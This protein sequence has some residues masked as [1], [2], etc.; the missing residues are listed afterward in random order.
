[1]KVGTRAAAPQAKQLRGLVA[2]GLC[3]LTALV[4]ANSFTAGFVMDGKAV[5]QDPRIRDATAANLSLILDHSY[6]W[7]LAENGLYRPLATLSYLFNFAILGNGEQPGGYHA[8]NLLLHLSNVLLVYALAL[9]LWKKLWPAAAMAALWGVHP[10]LT[11]AVTNIAGRPD[12]LA[13][14]AVLGGFLLYLK[15]T[16][17]TGWRKAVWLAGL[18][19]AAMA[20]AFSKESAIALPGVIAVY[21]LIYWKE[22]RQIRGLALGLLASGLPVVAMLFARIRVLG[23]VLA[24]QIPLRDNPLA[25]AG[26]LT[27]RLTAVD[28]AFRYLG[29][30][31]WPARLSCDYSY[32]Q[33]PLE[34][35]TAGDWAYWTAA[36]LLVAAM[37]WLYR[38]N[39]AGLFPAAFALVA[40]LPAS[41]LIV[42]VGTIMAERLAYL[43]SVG[44]MAC[45][46]LAAGL[47]LRRLPSRA[48]AAMAAAVW[49][50]AFG[51][52]TWARNADWQ[53]DLSLARS[54]VRAAPGSYK[55]HE[56][57]AMALFQSNPDRA[58]VDEAI[59]E[60]RRSMAVLDTL[61]DRERDSETY[62]LAGALYLMQGD[63]LPAGAERAEDFQRAVA[64]LQRCQA[65]G[66]AAAAAAAKSTAN[67]DVYRMLSLAYLRSGDLGQALQ[68][69]EEARAAA[70]LD[71]QVYRQMSDALLAAGRR[72]DA[73]VALVTGSLVTSDAGLRQELLRLYRDGLDKEGCA[74]AQGPYGPAINP[75][76]AVVRRHICEASAGAL[77][78]AS[79]AGRQDL[80]DAL[81]QG[82][83]RDYGCR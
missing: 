78:A 38:W 29:L 57:L 59:A 70:P 73:A 83:A 64:C 47:A 3:A 10:L 25:G 76:C 44:V 82:F 24:L 41:N 1:M 37:V 81:R 2:L 56:M 60:V 66:K 49:I 5:V 68:S 48:I 27:G 63:G 7:P 16:E 18:A 4:Y 30:L 75:A 80:L 17:A 15:S 33:I 55:T 58:G 79:A 22:R 9:R 50:A 36:A 23:G 39:R 51:W 11:E 21:E 28:V 46:V 43:P 34:R 31:A 61:P 14:M 12:L 54:A 13:A 45:V 20:G 65:I 67:R 42:P 19:A 71:P 52:C 26:F 62:R 72:D 6:W 40:W 69:A 53:N 32:N 8:V 77:Q 35:G 74:I